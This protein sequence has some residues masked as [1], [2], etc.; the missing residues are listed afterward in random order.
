MYDYKLL[1]ALA[2]VCKERGFE[3]ASDKLFITQSAVSQRI[4]TLEELMGQILITRMSPPEPTDM[5]K[6][7]IKHYHQVKQLE[8]EINLTD[9]HSRM[10]IGLNADSL[11]TWFMQ[12][13]SPYLEQENVLIELKVDD[14]DQTSQFLKNGEVSGCISSSENSLQGC[15]IHHLGIMEYSMVCTSEF[16]NK[17]FFEGFSFHNIKKAPAV[18]FNR[19]DKL[20]QRC[21]NNHFD[22]L[23]VKYPIHYIPSSEQFLSMILMNQAYGVVPLIQCEE[24]I[25]N[26]Q[27]MEINVERIEV[28][29]YWHHW[30]INTRP[31]EHLTVMAP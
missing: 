11:A 4:K 28:N 10:S 3:K 31:M 6:K 2:M 25:A 23:P 5:G 30:N 18:V 1:E 29:L 9:F 24:L 20:H 15:N 14:Q 16:Y 22:S 17:W 27:L 13:I 26:K 8:D 12:A 21:L 7:L 19:K